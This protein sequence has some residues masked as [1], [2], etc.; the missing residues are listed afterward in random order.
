MKLLKKVSLIILIMIITPM[1][2]LAQDSSNYDE[3][4]AP[5]INDVEGLR[6]DFKQ[7]TQNPEN[8]E[9]TFEMILDSNLDSDRVK[10][11]WELRTLK[12]S[13]AVFLDPNDAVEYITIQK[14]RSYTLPIT[15]VTTTEGVIELTGK[16]ES[17][18]AEATF[19]VSVRKTFG[20]NKAGEVKPVTQEYLQ[21]RTVMN[22]K[23]V[24]LGI[25]IVIA[26]MMTGIFGFKKFVKWLNK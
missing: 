14:G 1:T 7:H 6:A 3:D 16:A 23:N 19:L 24:I 26:I 11:T 22:V 13:G 18:R 17:F 9:I 25:L 20:T 2:L 10:I 15:I 4:V 8:R 12:G 21:A 5:E